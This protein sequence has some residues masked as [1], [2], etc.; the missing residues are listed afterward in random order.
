MDTAGEGGDT[1]KKP[2]E[3]E[4]KVGEVASQGGRKLGK[5]IKEEDS[6]LPIRR[7]DIAC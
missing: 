4:V 5:R 3:K 2:V 1:G 6:S 7:S